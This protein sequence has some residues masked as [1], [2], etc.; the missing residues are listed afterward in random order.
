[1]GTLISIEIIAIHLVRVLKKEVL[2]LREQNARI[3]I[4]LILHPYII[5]PLA[6]TLYYNNANYYCSWF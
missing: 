6:R 2:P 4:T 3:I 1:M 5:Q